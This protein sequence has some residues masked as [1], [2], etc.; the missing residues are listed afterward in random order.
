MSSNNLGI[1]TEIWPKFNLELQRKV[2]ALKGDPEAI[3][4]VIIALTDSF[5]KKINSGK[6]LNRNTRIQ[7][8]KKL[9]KA[10]QQETREITQLLDHLGGRDMTLF[11]INRSIG[12]NL[13]ISALSTIGMRKEVQEIKLVTK[14]NVI[15]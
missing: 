8:A 1:N 6:L 5:E 14:Q 10:F 2:T 13:K 4:H 3:L 7:Q 15:L 9:Q 11:W 12:V